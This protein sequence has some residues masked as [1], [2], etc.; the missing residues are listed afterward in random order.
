MGYRMVIRVTVRRAASAALGAVLLLPL[1]RAVEGPFLLT[2]TH[3]MEEPRNLEMTPKK[4][5]G[6]TG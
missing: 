6:Q 1:G 5:C 3:R 4:R 2:Y